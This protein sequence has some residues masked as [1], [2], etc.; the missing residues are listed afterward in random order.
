[1]RTQ[2]ERERVRGRLADVYGSRW[3]TAGMGSV[4]MLWAEAE[5]P[6]SSCCT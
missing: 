1:M 2:T 5:I 3:L 6:W 4:F